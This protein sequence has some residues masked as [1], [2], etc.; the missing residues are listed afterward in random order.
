[1]LNAYYF[2]E[3]SL[4]FRAFM[5]I[6]V[7][8][9]LVFSIMSICACSSE[10]AIPVS[11]PYGGEF[12][13]HGRTLVMGLAACGFCHGGKSDPGSALSGGRLFYD[14]YGEVYSPNL[15]SAESG[16][17]DWS[18]SDIVRVFRSAR[19]MAG[20]SLSRDAHRGFEWI[21]DH[22]A[23]SI[24]AYLKNL[25]P[26]ENR[27]ERRSLSF[28]DRNITGFMEINR[29]VSGFVPSIDQ[30][31]PVEYGKYLTDHVARCTSCHNT[32]AT[33]FTAE[34]YLGGGAVVKIE[35]GEKVA[36]NIAGS[37]VSGLGGWSE[38]NIVRYLRSGTSPAGYTSDPDYCPVRFF[39]NAE[40]RD[41]VALAKYLKSLVSTE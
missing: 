9:I 17:K 12:I 15:T 2:G 41:L 32:P 5:R 7:L 14:S 31:F 24:A 13:S 6:S 25:P 22:D 30:K 4:F 3:Y 29:E 39:S 20:D 1:M 28:L 27:V 37:E 16:L 19:N 26:L 23:V 35:N 36:P 34:I 38:E 40:E 18:Y 33:L 10:Q 21:S 11:N 8:G